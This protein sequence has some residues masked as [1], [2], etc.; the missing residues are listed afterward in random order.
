METRLAAIAREASVAHVVKALETLPVALPV[1]LGMV[2]EFN[3]GKS[4]LVNALLGADLLPAMAVPTTGSLTIVEFVRGLSEPSRYSRSEEG[5]TPIGP[6]EFEAIATGRRAGVAVLK[7]APPEGFDE[8]VRL[9]DTP[10]LASTKEAHTDLTLA[11]LPLLDGV[12]F[13]V[14]IHAGGINGTSREVLESPVLRAIRSRVGVVLTKAANRTPADRDAVRATVMKELADLLGGDAAV[15]AT[16]IAVTDAKEGQIA[17]LRDLFQ[18]LFIEPKRELAV[19]R[20]LL[21]LA[22]IADDLAHSLGETLRAATLDESGMDAR[23]RES[24]KCSAELE[25]EHA[26]HRGKLEQFDRSLNQSLTAL[27]GSFAPRFAAAKQE[28]LPGVSAAYLAD[29]QGTINEL[30]VRLVGDGAGPRI[31]D[32]SGAIAAKLAGALKVRDLAVN[33]VTG[34]II[35]VMTLGAGAAASG[36]AA[37]GEAAAA[38]AARAGVKSLASTA[39]KGAAKAA[40]KGWGAFVG[41]GAMFLANVIDQVNPMEHVGDLVTKMAI[42]GSLE[43]EL[44]RAH[45]RIGREL[46]EHVAGVYEGRY[47]EPIAARTKD[48]RAQVESA[49]QHRRDTREVHHQRLSQ[50]ERWIDEVKQIAA[51]LRAG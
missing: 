42:E 11:F 26:K 19:R 18:S 34:A 49:R 44:L 1:M 23:I 38:S 7:I 47:F 33:V 43:Q 25:K 6:A 46:V 2:G 16:R 9:V 12:V 40:A 30:L 29:L 48:A 8:D 3:A 27:A 5:D 10:G 37:A 14:D 31:F 17:E 35:A 50:V 51:R 24:E 15:A 36:A 32:P 39:T 20:R 28:T 21:H 4:T 13:C 41:K 22:D 45:S